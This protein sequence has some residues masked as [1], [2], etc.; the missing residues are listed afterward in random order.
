MSLIFW[1][2]NIHISNGDIATPLLRTL[3][4]KSFLQ[5]STAWNVRIEE[6]TENSGNFVDGHVLLD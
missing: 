5:V 2:R 1:V 4:T 6:V 3:I